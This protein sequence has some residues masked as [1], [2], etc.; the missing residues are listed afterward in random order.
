FQTER[1]KFMNELLKEKQQLLQQQFENRGEAL[2]RAID[3]IHASLLYR[4]ESRLFTL[5]E[6]EQFQTAHIIEGLN[7]EVN[8]Y[9]EVIKL[10]ESTYRSSINAYEAKQKALAQAQVINEKFD[11]YEEKNKQFIRLQGQ[12]ELIKEKE[13]RLET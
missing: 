3:S 10:D 4:D 13:L 11:Q 9:E 1:Y 5:L 7:E 8:H 2:Q 12:E 6:S